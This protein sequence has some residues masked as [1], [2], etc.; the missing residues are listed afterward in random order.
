[1]SDGRP[2]CSYDEVKKKAAEF[3]LYGFVI[4]TVAFGADA[5]ARFLK[6]IADA[7]G[8]ISYEASSVSGLVESF[9]LLDTPVRGL[10]TS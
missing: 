3:A 8:G 1:M 9:A 2:T 6:D 7:T 10:L 5:D 4:D